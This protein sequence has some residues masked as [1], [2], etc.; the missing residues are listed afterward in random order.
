MPKPSFTTAG[1]L[2]TLI[3]AYFEQIQNNREPSAKETEEQPPTSKKNKSKESEPPT[4]T[5]LALF[6]G[7]NSRKAFDDYLKNGRFANTLKRGQLLVESAYEKNLHGS[8]TGALFALKSMGWN[9]GDERAQAENAAFK[10]VQIEVFD[11]PAQP[12]ENERD[13]TL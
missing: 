6:L 7:F 1:G 4:I 12:A 5:G 9:G 2:A 10:S 8:A 11:S 13:V 3:D